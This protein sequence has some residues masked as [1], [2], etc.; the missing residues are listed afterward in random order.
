MWLTLKDVSS[1]SIVIHSI[2]FFVKISSISS[3]LYILD[4]PVLFIKS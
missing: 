1:L 3:F 4:I 2:E